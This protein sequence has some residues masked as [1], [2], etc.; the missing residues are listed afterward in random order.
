MVAIYL[1]VL[2]STASV[3]ISSTQLKIHKSITLKLILERSDVSNGLMMIQDSSPVAG[4]EMF[5]Y[6]SYMLSQLRKEEKQRM[7]TLCL[8]SNLKM[9]TSQV[10][11]IRVTQRMS[12]SQ[13][14]QIKLL[15][16]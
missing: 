12:F 1:L 14:E 7:A 16:R 10:Y 6:G 3:C 15:K 8:N 4:M 9:L 11:R 5:S 2:I 13:S